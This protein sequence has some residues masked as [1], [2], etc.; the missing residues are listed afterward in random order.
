MSSPRKPSKGDSPDFTTSSQSS[1][2]DS[3]EDLRQRQSAQFP[4]NVPRDTIPRGTVIHCVNL[5]ETVIPQ[6][7]A[8]ELDGARND[9]TGIVESG[10][11]TII[12][13]MFKQQI[14]F[15]LKIPTTWTFSYLD[16]TKVQNRVIGIAQQPININE[17]GD[18]LIDGVTQAYVEDASVS[19]FRWAEP[20]NGET[21]LQSVGRYGPIEILWYPEGLGGPSTG[22]PLCL[23]R[24][25]MT[26]QVLFLS[27][28][29]QEDWR[30]SGGAYP[31]GDPVVDCKNCDPD[32]NNVTGDDF[33]VH[34]PRDRNGN[35]AGADPAVYEGDVIKYM[36]AAY[37]TYSSFDP[38]S[39]YCISDYLHM[40]KIKDIRIQGVDGKIPT[41]WNECD[42]S[43]QTGEAGTFNLHDFASTIVAIGSEA[44]VAAMPRHKSTEEAQAD[45][46]RVYL[47]D[48]LGEADGGS[49][50]VLPNTGDVRDS[51]S[52]FFEA[53]VGGYP[54][55]TVMYIQRWK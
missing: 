51:A 38:F 49:P 19:N 41:G 20:K 32:G 1:I 28:K 39:P 10:K 52:D 12:E 7:G 8:V 30:E 40:G 27:A 33:T 17:V 21:V 44:E 54:T 55:C 25:T 43:E 35:N 3:V 14:L 34:L 9:V 45:I 47:F 2:I 50:I 42:G 29:A 36:Y 22:S 18:V 23:V 46:N 24:L 16:P 5:T 53:Q 15:A 31:N 37:H 13:N 26:P 4:G 6:Y 11:A 48:A